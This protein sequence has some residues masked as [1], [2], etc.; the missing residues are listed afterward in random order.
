[1]TRSPE[2]PSVEKS[3]IVAMSRRPTDSARSREAVAHDTKLHAAGIGVQATILKTAL[4][5]L[6]KSL[7]VRDPSTRR[8]PR[9][10]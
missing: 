9:N 4:R 6:T 8:A 10:S 2:S 3:A 7:I 1:M 5:T